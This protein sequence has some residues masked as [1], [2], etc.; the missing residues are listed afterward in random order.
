MRP[1]QEIGTW[2]VPLYSITN[3][4]P[5]SIP[6]SEYGEKSLSTFLRMES[7][8]CITKG[9][10]TGRDSELGPVYNLPQLVRVYAGKCLTVG[11]GKG[12]SKAPGKG[13]TAVFVAVSYRPSSL[14]S[15]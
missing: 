10:V 1:R 3:P 15:E 8:S 14:V 9:V 6:D 13:R 11:F 2:F 4:S 12:V 7:Q 5:K